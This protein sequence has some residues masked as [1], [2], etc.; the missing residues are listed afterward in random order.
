M[1]D[2]TAHDVATRLAED[3]PDLDD[4]DLPSDEEEDGDPPPHDATVAPADPDAEDVDP[5]EEI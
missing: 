4:A 1:T 3:E 2:E 5:G